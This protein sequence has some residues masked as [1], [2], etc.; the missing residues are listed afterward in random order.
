M[1][2]CRYMNGI[3]CSSKMSVRIRF[4]CVMWVVIGIERGKSRGA[5]AELQ[6]PRCYNTHRYCS[7]ERGGG[8]AARAVRCAGNAGRGASPTAGKRE[9]FSF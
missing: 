9:G 4:T 5:A 8:P 2:D 6:Y 7:R 3:T 1:F